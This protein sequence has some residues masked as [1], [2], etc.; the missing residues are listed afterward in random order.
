MA[1]F[2]CLARKGLLSVQHRLEWAGGGNR[3]ETKGE[4]RVSIS[5]QGSTSVGVEEA[6]QK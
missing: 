1:A 6:S 4:L 3:H 5:V 2:P